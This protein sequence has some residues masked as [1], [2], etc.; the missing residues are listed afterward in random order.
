MH[1]FARSVKVRPSSRSPFKAYTRQ[2][3]GKV[4]LAWVQKTAIAFG[5]VLVSFSVALF[6][7]AFFFL[8]TATWKGD[9]PL[10]IAV[11]TGKHDSIRK[12]ISLVWIDPHENTVTLVP[13]PSNLQVQTA[14]SGLYSTS[15]LYGLYALDHQPVH[16]FLLTL[17]RNT[18]IDVESLLIEDVS[19]PT[20]RS[21]PLFFT[22]ALLDPKGQHSVGFADMFSVWWYVVTHHPS[23]KTVA[24]PDTLIQKNQTSDG[25]SY[26]FDDLEYDRFVEKRFFNT[27]IQKE[28]LSVAVV[29]ASGVPRVASSVGRL[30]SILGINIL[31]VTDVPTAQTSGRIGVAKQEQVK[32]VTVKLI[33]R[34]MQMKAV[35]DPSLSQEYRSDVVVFLGGEQAKDLTQ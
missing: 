20:D 21:L 25:K 29:N 7:L 2:Q 18:R 24:I 31:S 33:E 19:P 5:A 4:T 10:G 13:L 17:A 15:S 16:R 1:D 6:L 22:H 32:S 14:G 3:E 34:Y 26:V 35:V 8:S 11:L 23:V 12:E 27:N 28:A 30:F 9:R